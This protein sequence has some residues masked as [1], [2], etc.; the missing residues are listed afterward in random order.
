MNYNFFEAIIKVCNSHNIDTNLK[1][2]GNI[3]KKIN[4][5]IAR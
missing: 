4:E 1:F 2:I 5:L 3:N